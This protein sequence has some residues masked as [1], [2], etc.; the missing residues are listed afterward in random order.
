M[1]GVEKRQEGIC[2][3]WKN[4]ERENVWGEKTTGGNMSRVSKMTGDNMS[5][6]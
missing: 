3:G 5:G 2:P 1:Y 4:N 6:R